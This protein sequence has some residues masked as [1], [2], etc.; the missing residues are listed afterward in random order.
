MR[1]PMRPSKLWKLFLVGSLVGSAGLA[2]SGCWLGYNSSWGAG[3]KAQNRLANEQLHH[4]LAPTAPRTRLV[5]P[6]S[7]PG[8]TRFGESE[9]G[10]PRSTGIKVLKVRAYATGQ[11]AA[12]NVNWPKQLEETLEAT[13]SILTPTL[14]IRLE[15]A[16]T[17][18][19]VA[20]D[21]DDLGTLLQALTALDPGD[22]VDWVMG[23][24]ASVPRFAL[25]FH[26]IGLAKLLAK[27]YVVR[28]LNSVH[29]FEAVD[30][31]FPDLTDAK[32]AE[33]RHARVRHKTSTVF[34]HE[35][36]HTLGALHQADPTTIMNPSYSD[37]VVAFSPEAVQLM[38]R[39]LQVR[40]R[41]DAA[42]AMAKVEIEELKR[43]GSRWAPAE[44]DQEVARLERQY[45]LAKQ[46][47]SGTLATTGGPSTSE[48]GPAP[49]LIGTASA[50]SD[51]D[52]TQALS[53]LS[54][55]DR[56]A[57][58]AALAE[59]RAG[60]IK[61]AWK[62]A[63]PLF[64]RYRAVQPVQELRC[65]LAVQQGLPWQQ[66]RVHCEAMLETPPG[67]GHQ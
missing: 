15:V 55:A 41:A 6:E 19:W 28:S 58:G 50:L 9:L 61:E 59:Q 14:Q 51:K 4:N 52:A 17:R 62:K 33:V 60:R 10:Q 39:V 20:R 44:R 3:K 30:A 43:P 16:E 46:P 26:D 38:Q 64:D 57:Y 21:E 65:Q 66:A 12:E 54:Q 35:L 22:G 67:S 18:P 25:A 32:R 31:Q 63:E 49:A 7:E 56:T 53:A 11:Y 27:H 36:G 8:Q 48:A 5:R 24:A 13:N 45:G 29:E 2:T 47:P 42:E 23:L 1:A 40:A 34:L 37:K